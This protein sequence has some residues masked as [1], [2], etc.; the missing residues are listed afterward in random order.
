MGEPNFVI[1]RTFS[2]E[3]L[4]SDYSTS[5]SPRQTEPLRLMQFNI[6][7]WRDTHHAD[8][9]DQ[10]L[11][12]VLDASPDLLVLNE[13]LHPY[14]RPEDPAYFNL[15]KKGNGNGF[16]PATPPTVKDSYLHRL[17]Q[18]SG[19]V[20]Y[21]F[22]EAIHNGY[23]GSFGFGNAILS[24]LPLSGCTHTVL[25]ASSFE[26]LGERRIEAEDR[27]V[28]SVL[29][30][31]TP[32]IRVFTSHLDQLDEHLRLQQTKRILTEMRGSAQ[33][34]M[35]VGDL[36]TY[37]ASDFSDQGWEELSAMW[38]KKGW[39]EPPRRS[40][41]LEELCANQFK[42]AHYLCERNVDAVPKA[43]CWTIEPLFRID[44]ALMGEEATGDWNVLHCDRFTKATC[45]DH[46]PII[47]DMIASH[48]RSR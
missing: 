48:M 31:A 38:A 34:C 1:P 9:F 22:G 27:S 5:S 42:D 37:Q 47:V 8:N 15:V 7:G 44:Y 41:T 24:K 13:V 23:F 25:K 14:L 30:H 17:A 46:F 21:T 43:T 6:H 29:V 32:P 3:S 20:F 11:Q 2:S 36:N 26:Y 39:G 45:S 16:V 12:A 4:E 28:S 40:A 33:P 10:V 35:L 19:L 18:A